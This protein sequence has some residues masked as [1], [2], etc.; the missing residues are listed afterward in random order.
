MQQDIKKGCERD[1][2]LVDNRLRTI[3]EKNVDNRRFSNYNKFCS[4][5]DWSKIFKR[6]IDSTTNFEYNNRKIVCP[7][8][9]N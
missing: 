2:M 3:E 5:S 9:Y 7:H 6:G 1:I 8:G 4:F